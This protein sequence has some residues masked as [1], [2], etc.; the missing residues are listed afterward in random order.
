MSYFNIIDSNNNSYD[1]NFAQIQMP[2]NGSWVADILVNTEDVLTG[3]VTLQVSNEENNLFP[4]TLIGTVV[5]NRSGTYL[6]QFTS[7][8]V[9]GNAGL[10]TII[11]PRNY[12]NTQMSSIVNAIL[13]DCGETLDNSVSQTLLNKIIPSWTIIANKGAIALKSLLFFIDP[14]LSGRF[15]NNGNYWF[16][17]ETWDTISEDYFINQS[18]QEPHEDIWHLSIVAPYIVPGMNIKDIGNVNYVEHNIKED[19]FTSTI[20]P[21]EAA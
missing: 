4:F 17:Y 20:Y 21:N 6:A 5:D 2:I 15:L 8:I 19:I 14:K 18:W 3:K 13:K 10:G 12:T 16:G 11:K 1:I 7:R 9:A